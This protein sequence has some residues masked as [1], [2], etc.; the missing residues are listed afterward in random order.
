MF[1]VENA[2]GPQVF[3]D[4]DMVYHA[5]NITLTKMLN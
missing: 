1:C 5:T 4:E 2:N 3:T